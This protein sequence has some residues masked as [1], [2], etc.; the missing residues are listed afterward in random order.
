QKVIDY[1]IDKYGQKQVAQIITY[2]SMAARSSIKDVGRVLDIPLSE[3]NKVTK[4][5]PEH[6]SANLNKV[7][8]PDGVQKKLKDAMNA[9][10]NKA[11]EEFRAMAE[12]DDEIGQMIQTAKRLEGSVR[13]TG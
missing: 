12:Q 4:A 11:A 1:V 2:G 10:Q 5:F 9:D 7:L 13:N 8:A 3:V 6:L